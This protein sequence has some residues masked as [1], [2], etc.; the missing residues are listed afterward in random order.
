[1]LDFATGIEAKNYG[2]SKTSDMGTLLES[3]KILFP[4]VVIAGALSFHI[5]VR[6]QN[7]QVG[8]QNQQLINQQEDLMNLQKELILEEQTLKDPKTLEFL[9]LGNLGMIIPPT[10]R[11]ILSAPSE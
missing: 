4:L 8:Y 1:M 10:D 3:L 9:A 11:I 6:S 7:I 5:W 2:L